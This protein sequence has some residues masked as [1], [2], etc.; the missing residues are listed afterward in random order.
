MDSASATAEFAELFATSKL[1]H[2]STIDL[3]ILSL[4]AFEPIKEDMARRGWWDEDE[5]MDGQ[6][7]R[8][9]AF[10]LVPV[11]GPC[12]YLTVRP[13]LSEE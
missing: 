8:L 3:T 7:T 5:P 11:L 13:G 6:M 12:A 4:F 10:S 1:V 2:V 9:L